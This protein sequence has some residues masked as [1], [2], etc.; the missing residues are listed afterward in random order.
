M[1]LKAIK[2]Q[3]ESWE[4]NY[5]QQLTD[6]QMQIRLLEG[7]CERLIQDRFADAW[8]DTSLLQSLLEKY[9]RFQAEYGMRYYQAPITIL[10]VEMTTCWPDAITAKIKKFFHENLNYHGRVFTICLEGHL[11][12]TPDELLVLKWYMIKWY[13]SDYTYRG[14]N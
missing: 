9:P 10:K 12:F 1:D 8:A 14:G 11:S 4:A 6:S 13:H 3:F 2:Q 7:K 5:Q